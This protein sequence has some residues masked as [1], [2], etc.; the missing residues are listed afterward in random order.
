MVV[1]PPRKRTAAVIC[2]CLTRVTS[3]ISRPH[4]LAFALR[5]VRVP[6]DGGEVGGQGKD[7]LALLVVDGE[8]IGRTLLLIFLLGRVQGAEFG[9]PVGLQRIGD[10]SIGGVHLPVAMLRLVGLVLGALDLSVPQA[11]GLV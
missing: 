3:S 4:A 7:A 9:V 2:R 6:P 11:V 5:G 8:R 10:E 1:A